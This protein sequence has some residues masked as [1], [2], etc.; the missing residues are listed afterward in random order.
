MSDPTRRCRR[1]RH[2]HRAML[3]AGMK[4]GGSRAAR[5]LGRVWRNPRH[6]LP[7]RAA[8]AWRRACGREG[9]RRR[10]LGPGGR[11]L[12]RG[13][14]ASCRMKADA[15]MRTRFFPPGGICSRQRYMWASVQTVR[16]CPK[17]CS[18][19]SV[20]RTDGQKPR[21][22]TRGRGD[23]R[24]RG[25][26]ASRFSVHRARRRQLLSGDP[27]RHPDGVPARRPDAASEPRIACGRNGSS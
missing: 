3:F 9:R 20:W 14:T 16:G 11:R 23:R 2:P 1:H 21:Q 8:C 17:H 15:S 13:A 22:R 27:H 12:H 18:F 19:C 25:A 7:G 6:A 10:R 5:C 4:S 24:D 26:A